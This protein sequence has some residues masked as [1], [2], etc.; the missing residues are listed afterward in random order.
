MVGEPAEV[1]LRLFK[2]EG[3]SI[4][5]TSDRGLAEL[6]QQAEARGKSARLELAALREAVAGL[7]SSSEIPNKWEL[8]RQAS[9]AKKR[10][11]ALEAIASLAHQAANSD[12]GCPQDFRFPILELNDAL[13]NISRPVAPGVLDL[14]QL[15]LV[16]WDYGHNPIALCAQPSRPLGSARN[17]A[18]PSRTDPEPSSF[19]K[20]PNHIS[21]ADLYRGFGQNGSFADHERIGQYLGPKT[22]FGVNPGFEAR[23]GSLSVRVKFGETTSEPFTARIFAAL[24]YNV[25]RTYHARNLKIRYD[26]RLLREF[27]LRKPVTTRIIGL[28]FVPLHTIQ[29]QKRHDPF[30][31]ILAAVTRTGVSL[32]NREL[33]TRLFR[34]PSLPHPEDSPENFDERTE[35]ELDY[36]IFRP[37]NVKV[38]PEGAETVGPWDLNALDHP[39]RRELKGLGLLGAWLGWCDS[40]FENTRLRV[41]KTSKGSEL[42]HY[43]T[44]LG[45]GLG[46]ANGPLSRRAED[47]HLFGWRF[48]K[49]PKIQGKGRMTVPFKIIGYEPIEDTL[50]FQQMTYE[51]ARWMARMIGQLTENQIVQAL[52]ASGFDTLQVKLYTEKLISRRDHMIRDLGLSE[53]IPLLRPLAAISLASE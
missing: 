53:E 12:K 29:L 30:D 44:D 36:L 48:T 9:K 20:R 45:G 17:D 43:L 42:K 1:S 2:L 47:P 5:L 46:R 13:R 8:E 25:D 35:A 28:G 16:Y 32:S 24:G 21:S 40:R 4:D 23:L 52:T 18:D 26:R 22:G 38:K 39:S 37:A 10:V 11:R 19:W 27:N 41:V 6:A 51:D 31:F 7:D 33:R 49:P 34:N 15:P 14:F 50:P 3:E